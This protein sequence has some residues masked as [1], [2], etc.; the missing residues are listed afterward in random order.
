M[1]LHALVNPVI[2]VINPNTIGDLYVS[3]GPSASNSANGY[4]PQPTFKLFAGVSMQVQAVSGIGTDGPNI[5]HIDSLNLQGTLR[6]VW[7]N[8]NVEAID[9]NAGKGGDVV[10]MLNQ[11]WIVPQLVE[12]WDQD[13]PWTHFIVQL[14]NGK[15]DGIP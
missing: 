4:K 3:T 11:W 7:I 1:N 15:P 13:G 12:S 8:Q 5:Q 9:R 14:Q 6:S 2:A 10:F